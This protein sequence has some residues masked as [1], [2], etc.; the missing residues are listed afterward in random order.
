MKD[1][2]VPNPTQ[3]PRFPNYPDGYNCPDS[4]TAQMAPI[5]QGRGATRWVPKIKSAQILLKCLDG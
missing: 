4:P 3:L 1:G 5:A 2:K